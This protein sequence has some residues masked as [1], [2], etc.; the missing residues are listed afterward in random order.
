M[1][2]TA[3][4]WGTARKVLVR[5][6]IVAAFFTSQIESVNVASRLAI[7]DSILARGTLAIERSPFF[8]ALDTVYLNS[9]FYSNKPPLLSFYSAAIAAPLHALVTFTDPGWR[10]LYFVVVLTSSGFALVALALLLRALRSRFREHE[11]SWKWLVVAAAGATCTLP[12]ARTY[13]DHIVESP[14]ILGIFALLLRFRDDGEAWIPAAVGALT[15]LLAVM[16]PLPGIV[17]GGTTLL[18]FAVDWLSNPRGE[19]GPGGLRALSGYSLVA[20]ALV[21][22]GVYVHYLLYGVPLS[23]YFTPELQ[24]WANVPGYPDSHWLADPSMP[25]LKPDRIVARLTQLGV[26]Y[27]T[28]ERT[29]QLMSAYRDSVRNPITYA[30]ARYFRYDQLSLTPLVVFCLALGVRALRHRE[31]RYRLEWAWAIVGVAGLFAATVYLRGVPGGSFGNRLLLPVLP[32][33]V[34][35]GAFVLSTSAQRYAFKGLALVS[36]A[37]MAPGMI[38][39]WTTPGE[40]FLWLNLTINLSALAAVAWFV[41]SARAPES[42]TR[43]GDRTA[44]TGRIS[45]AVA[46]AILLVLEF[47]FYL[48]TVQFTT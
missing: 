3:P 26:P 1:R 28:T 41:T 21:G 5:G 36:L 40:P 18:Y 7:V 37:M 10:L 43:W 35:T 24:L 34:C 16:H 42:V 13:N 17:L 11:I 15:G 46:F 9:H 22:G 31:C 38:G 8:N 20:L 19:P 33:A 32:L 27:A 23:F 44:S 14:I 30:A 45:I 47:A 2:L 4:G 12:F 39:P 48:S 29:L 25:G 6:A